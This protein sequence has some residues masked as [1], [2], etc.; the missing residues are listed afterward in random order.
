[1]HPTRNDSRIPLV[2]GSLIG[3]VIANF[4]IYL[5]VRVILALGTAADLHLLQAID[6]FCAH[7]KPS[8]SGRPRLNSHFAFKV[9]FFAAFLS[10][11]VYVSALLSALLSYQLSHQLCCYALPNLITRSLSVARIALVR[12]RNSS[13]S[14]RST[15]RVHACQPQFASAAVSAEVSRARRCCKRNVC[16]VAFQMCVYLQTVGKLYC[17]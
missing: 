1:M 15:N 6:K 7:I 2:I 14:F 8:A 13:A 17:P 3:A 16:L 4:A 5:G 10:P 11:A 12:L 9:L